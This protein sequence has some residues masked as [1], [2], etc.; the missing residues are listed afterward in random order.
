MSADLMSHFV[1]GGIKR[2]GTP[3]HADSPPF[4]LENCACHDQGLGNFLDALSTRF[5]GVI[6]V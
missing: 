5:I 2:R 4:V 3:I 1:A 6:G